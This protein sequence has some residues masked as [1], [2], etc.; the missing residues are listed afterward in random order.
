MPETV[1]LAFLDRVNDEYGSQYALRFSLNLAN[2]HHRH[3]HD[4]LRLLNHLVKNNANLLGE[5][6]KK[7]QSLSM[8]QSATRHKLR[9]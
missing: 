9:E 4:L 6:E 1:D 2:L 7:F 8:A 3:Q 5:V